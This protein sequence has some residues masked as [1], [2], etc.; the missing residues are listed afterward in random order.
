MVFP[1][2]Y[3]HNCSVRIPDIFDTVIS[4]TNNSEFLTLTVDGVR[5]FV[6]APREKAFFG[7]NMKMLQKDE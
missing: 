4:T 3:I 1:R 7:L 6:P 2:H 5:D